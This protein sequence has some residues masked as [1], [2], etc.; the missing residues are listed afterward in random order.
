MAREKK[1][2]SLIM[3]DV[4]CFKL[5]NDNYGHLLGDDCL[6]SVSRVINNCSNRPG[7]LAARFGGEEFTVLLPDTDTRGAVHVAESIRAKVQ[8][9]KIAHAFSPVHKYVT[10]SLGVFSV[11]PEHSSDPQTLVE[12]SDKALYEAKRAG[13]NQVFSKVL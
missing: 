4:D 10:L 12:A 8:D 7:D 5:Y 6:R 9:L 1:A 13:R 11:F 2:L 3:C